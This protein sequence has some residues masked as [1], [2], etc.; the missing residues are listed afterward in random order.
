MY[1]S[2]HSSL[3]E[4]RNSS[5]RPVALFIDDG[6]VLNDNGLRA[7]EWRRLIGE[8]MPPR[9]GGSPEHW[10][11]A[12]RVVFPQIWANLLSRMPKF[13]SHHA[14]QH[15]YATEWMSSMCARVGVPSVPD[16]IAIEVHRA[17]SIYVGERAT[18]AIPGAADSVRTL[19]RAGYTL[20]MASGTPSWELQAI[21]SKMEI[22]DL[23]SRT[24]G[25]D[26][27]DHVKHGVGFYQRLFDD[28]GVAPS[29][30]LVIESDA[31]C[32]RWASEAGANAVWVDAEGRGAATS[33]EMLVSS[34]VPD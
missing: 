12:N 13:A 15:A 1:S 29:S 5:T 25:P 23:F 3:A 8:F 28:T 7:I 20:Y 11:S 10:M 19:H 9:L 17:L 6:G 31:A 26:L 30:A 2:R 21:L 22:N 18:C 4:F 14:F 33:L 34:L 32:C 24:Y 27:I 16:H